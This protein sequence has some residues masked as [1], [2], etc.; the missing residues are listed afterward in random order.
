MRQGENLLAR[1]GVL[2]GRLRN[3]VMAGLSRNAQVLRYLLDVAPGVGHTLLAKFAYLS[4]LLARQYLGKPISEMEYIFDE[5]GPFDAWRF[6]RARDELVAGGHITHGPAEIGGYPGFE[7]RPTERPVRYELT[8]PER[9]ILSWVAR[10]Y[11]SWTATDF[12]N[13]VVYT[14]KPMKDAKPGEH[15]NMDQMNHEPDDLEFNLEEM[16]AGERAAA[17]GR[18]RPLADVLN[19][20]RARHP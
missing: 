2:W 3:Q 18:V 20:L 8:E 17:E 7:M 16:L 19:E 11:A 6:Y 12:C 13:R 10:T 5:H 9:E 4:D 14:S 1:I 15:L